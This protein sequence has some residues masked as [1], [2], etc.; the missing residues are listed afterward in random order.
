MWLG[1][2]LLVALAAGAAT[3]GWWLLAGVVLAGLLAALA[4]RPDTVPP[5][6]EWLLDGART[7]AR[8]AGVP[9]FAAVFAIYLVPRYSALTALGVVLVVTAVDAAGFT[10]P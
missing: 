9:L 5:G 3:A 4:A 6:A 7:A 2:G 1:A 8:L 10:M